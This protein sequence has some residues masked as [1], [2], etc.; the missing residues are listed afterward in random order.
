VK[1]GRESVVPVEPVL[2]EIVVE[3]VGVLEEI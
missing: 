1:G 3:V 2:V